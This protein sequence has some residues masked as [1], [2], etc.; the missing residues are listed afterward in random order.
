MLRNFSKGE[1]DDG[2]GE[3]GLGDPLRWFGVLVPQSSRDAQRRFVNGM[4]DMNLLEKRKGLIVVL[5]E[6]IE[7]A[8]VLV[9]LQVS[10]KAIVELRRRTGRDGGGSEAEAVDSEMAK[11]DTERDTSPPEDHEE[12]LGKDTEDAAIKEE[13][14][15]LEQPDLSKDEGDNLNDEGKEKQDFDTPA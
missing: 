8:N 5:E 4:F 9:K 2:G 3:E 12:Y 15:S 10:E 1:G 7:V 11:S 6:S 14:R 13:D